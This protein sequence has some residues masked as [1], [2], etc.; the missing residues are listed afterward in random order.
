[1]GY[2]RNRKTTPFE[3]MSHEDMLSWLDKA[4]SGAVQGAAD[5]L[6]YAAGEIRK[7]AEDL[8]VRPQWV[9]WE[10]DGAHAFRTWSADL[11]NST[12]RLGDYSESASRW[13]TEA[14]NA[15]A[16]AQ[17]SV[18]RTDASAKAN[19]DAAR[20]ARN[21]PDASAV[22]KK[23]AET[24]MAKQE[25]NRQ[26]AA[27][28]M[29]R[30]AQSYAFSSL[31]MDGL[32]KPTF[33]TPPKGVLPD[34]EVQR[35]ASRRDIARAGAGGGS[36]GG[37][38]G[39]TTAHGQGFDPSVRGAASS[40]GVTMPPPSVG[41]H[42]LR[43]VDME[44]DGATTL[45]EAPPVPAASPPGQPSL[46]RPDL[47]LP[48]TPV[49]LPP[50]FRGPG[51]PPGP[52]GAGKPIGVPRLPNA[53]PGP[54]NPVAVGRQSGGDGITGGRPVP[55]TSGRSTGGLPRGT[56]IGGEGTQGRTPMGRVPSMGGMGAG[57]GMGTGA[58]QGG[59][60][61]GR[62]L[63]G[64]SGGVVGGRPQRS[65]PTGT[66]PFTPGGS[67]LARAAK[68]AEGGHGTHRGD[69]GERPDYLTEDEETWHTGDRRV[70][71][72]VID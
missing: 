61:G 63:A 30:L 13:L 16:A 47:G 17:A 22:A 31:Q 49:P 52:S 24:L 60:N 40:V 69:S 25:S 57:T 55:P 50:T 1:M 44:I 10:G 6:R 2:T 35:D 70:V 62:R 15:I 48:S 14:S 29:R 11:A 46:G 20:V 5:K 41:S 9:E 45:P 36:E 8:K 64:E 71:P 27:A 3:D 51:M 18:P 59:V 19:L 33:P 4:N 54:L 32:E 23:S 66:R 42:T 39:G 72:P 37:V 58:G 65:G 53:G 12:L 68:P 7:I 38:L 43:P 56:V 21:D 28:E 67:G 26:D 34:A